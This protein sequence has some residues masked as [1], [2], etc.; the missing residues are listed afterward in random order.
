[1]ASKLLKSLL[2]CWLFAIVMTLA[3]GMPVPQVVSAD[4][5]SLMM[6]SA[7]AAQQPG[8]IDHLSVTEAR[9][10]MREQGRPGLH[11][12]SYQYHLLRP[13]H[14]K[15]FGIARLTAA[16]AF[17]PDDRAVEGPSAKPFLSLSSFLADNPH[18]SRAPPAFF[19]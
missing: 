18:T 3:T 11:L 6:P 9:E 2:G 16:N 15:E 7:L 17:V 4:I 10:Y 19:A 5:I 13:Y 8:H 12:A 14:S 1:M